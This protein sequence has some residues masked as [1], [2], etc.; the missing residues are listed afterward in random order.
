MGQDIM[1]EK[2]NQLIAYLVAIQNFCKDIH[3]TCHGEAFFAKHLLAD[4]VYDGIDDFLD[5]LKETALLGS[6]DR[7]LP[8]PQYLKMAI[9]LIPDVELDDDL[10]NYKKLSDLLADTLRLLDGIETNNRGVNNLCDNIT[11]HLQN[12]YGLINLQILR[13]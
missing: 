9:P 12:N 1:T 10:E 11:G 4:R 2:I 13:A 5:E 3:Y 6:D 8:S 7:P